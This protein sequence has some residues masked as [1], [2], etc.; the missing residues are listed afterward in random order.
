ME[1]EATA[2]GQVVWTGSEY[3]FDMNDGIEW[4]A[5]IA[6]QCFTAMIGAV[7][8]SPDIGDDDFREAVMKTL[9]GGNL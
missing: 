2:I 6:A 1:N 9:L 8:E 4:N 5:D 3:K 7:A